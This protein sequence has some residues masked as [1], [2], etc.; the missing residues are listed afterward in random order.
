[1]SQIKDPDNK[2]NEFIEAHNYCTMLVEPDSYIRYYLDAK[3][4]SY[5]T[6]FFA[7]KIR[8]G[9]DDVWRDERFKMMSEVLKNIRPELLNKS[10][11][12]SR[13]LINAAINNDIERA[14]KLVNMHLAKLKL[15][16]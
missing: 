9:K 4:V 7:K 6:K 10:S 1:M 16:R 8:R 2:F 11:R 5:Y 15:K 3:M 13:K 14:K 12:Y